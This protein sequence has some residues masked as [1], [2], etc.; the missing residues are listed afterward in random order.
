MILLLCVNCYKLQ[1]DVSTG[2]LAFSLE[3]P[4]IHWF[5]SHQLAQNSASPREK[6]RASE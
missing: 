6:H 5:I 4:N 1:H 2:P 3:N